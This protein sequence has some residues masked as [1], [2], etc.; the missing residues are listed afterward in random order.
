MYDGAHPEIFAATANAYLDLSGFLEVEKLNPPVPPRADALTVLAENLGEESDI[1]YYGKGIRLL[2]ANTREQEVR[3]VLRSVK[4]L[5]QQGES[6][7]DII[8]L[9]RDFSFYAGL[10]RLSDE[11]GVPVSLPQ[12]AKLNNQPLTEL[13]Y[14]LLKKQCHPHRRWTLPICGRCWDARRLKCCLG[15]TPKNYCA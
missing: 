9:L 11:Y 15:L 8:I 12:S 5:L 1:A 2:E 3:T 6:A 7:D 14:L 10:R 13:V 4:K